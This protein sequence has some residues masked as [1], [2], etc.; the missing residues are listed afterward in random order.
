MVRTTEA[1]SPEPVFV[2][3]YFFSKLP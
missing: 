3:C 2:C 1:V